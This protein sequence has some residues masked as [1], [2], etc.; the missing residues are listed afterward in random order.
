MCK[1][2][3]NLVKQP[4][5]G[6]ICEIGSWI[7]ERN[8]GSMHTRTRQTQVLNSHLSL[9][10]GCRMSRRPS[11][12]LQQEVTQWT[13]PRFQNWPDHSVATAPSSQIQ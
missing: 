8:H 7:L 11:T 12:I 4:P 6:K 3:V 10:I 1:H 2:F 13:S 5:L 9:D